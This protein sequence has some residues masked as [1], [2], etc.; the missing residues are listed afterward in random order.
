ML[1]AAE[2]MEQNG[3]PELAHRIY[4]HVLSQEPAHPVAQSQIDQLGQ[5]YPNLVK[6]SASVPHRQEQSLAARD[7]LAQLQKRTEQQSAGEQR[8][9][10]GARQ[11]D[12]PATDS[13]IHP[14]AEPVAADATQLDEPPLW[15]Q[16]GRPVQKASTKASDPLPEIRPLRQIDSSQVAAIDETKTTS[17]EGLWELA[18]RPSTALS[19]SASDRAPGNDEAGAWQVSA[20]SSTDVRNKAT[21][22]TS[23]QRSE[24]DTLLDSKS[25]VQVCDDLP[26][27][28]IPLVEQM[29][30]SS[31][32]ERV[33]AVAALSQFGESARPAHLAVRAL[34]D[35]PEAQV[36]LFAAAALRDINGDAWD[37]VRV[38]RDLLNE[39]DQ[40]VVRYAAYLLGRM[41]PDAVDAVS[42]LE[43]ARDTSDM[44]TALH[45]A[46]AVNRIVPGEQASFQVLADGLKDNDPHVRWYAAVCLGAVSEPRE[47]DAVAAL[48]DALK[49]AEFPVAT[50]AALSLGGLGTSAH[51]AIDDLEQAARSSE[52][53]DVRDAAITALA[54]LKN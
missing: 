30:S 1:A 47:A 49:D 11:Q 52:S 48:V 42:D 40:D 15:A 13:K 3:K 38:L 16:E 51:A 27:E 14:L 19:D 10:E 2:R 54:C 32:T 26:S 28:L 50:A 21:A 53:S 46:E 41:G 45:A 35:D 12:Q 4:S 5:K 20:S 25:L 44:L 7:L 31:A 9:A 18:A 43:A 39:E 34:L 37:S 8:R 24:T 17:N 23:P 29:G 33:E 6:S 22:A 36:R